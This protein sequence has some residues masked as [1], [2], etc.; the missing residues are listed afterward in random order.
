[1]DRAFYFKHV[2]IVPLDFPTNSREE[3]TVARVEFEARMPGTS[4]KR[5]IPV[6]FLLSTYTYYLYVGEEEK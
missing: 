3:R 6:A 2:L 4:S 5:P 1:M